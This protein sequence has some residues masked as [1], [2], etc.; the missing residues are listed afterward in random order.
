MNA[1]LETLRDPSV[2]LLHADE[3]LLDTGGELDG[4]YA[5]DMLHLTPLA[6][7]TLN[8]RQL[9]PLLASLE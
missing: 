6:Y 9:L 3:V 5:L 1:Y 4:R 2:R 8:E 7:A